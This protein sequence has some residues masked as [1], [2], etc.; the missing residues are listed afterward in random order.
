M[1]MVGTAL[2][3]SSFICFFAYVFTAIRV[4]FLFFGKSVDYLSC[5]G[6]LQARL[7]SII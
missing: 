3:V 6:A 4:I 5:I 2:I 7:C 1:E